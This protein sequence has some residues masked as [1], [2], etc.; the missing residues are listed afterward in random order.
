MPR[1]VL[2]T[3]ARSVGFGSGRISREAAEWA[4]HTQGSADAD[5][6]VCCDIDVGIVETHTK[7]LFC[8][9]K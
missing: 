4:F 9:I 6:W 8:S 2:Q 5:S 3:W 7:I 1:G